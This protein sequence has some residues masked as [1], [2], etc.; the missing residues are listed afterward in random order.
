MNT[1]NM[2]MFLWRNKKKI[3]TEKCPLS[4]AKVISLD[5]IQVENQDYQ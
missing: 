5:K 2:I 3:S 1:H 4:G